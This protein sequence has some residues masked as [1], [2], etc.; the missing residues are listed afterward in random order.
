MREAGQGGKLAR[1]RLDSQKRGVDSQQRAV[2]LEGLP[3]T[4]NNGVT[5]MRCP[6][7][8]PD[9]RGLALTLTP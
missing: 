5:A 4:D 1:V 3:T 7:R 6:S 9:F 8:F 2:R